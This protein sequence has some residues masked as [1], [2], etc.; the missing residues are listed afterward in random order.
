[1][2]IFNLEYNLEFNFHQKIRQSLTRKLA[3]VLDIRVR[4]LR[5]PNH[6]KIRRRKRRHCKVDVE[7]FS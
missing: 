7:V 3:V 6:H 2:K 5:R 1:M 4:S